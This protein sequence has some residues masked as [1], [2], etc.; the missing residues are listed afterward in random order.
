MKIAKYLRADLTRVIKRIQF[1]D[2]FSR[3]KTTLTKSKNIID[4]IW[5]SEL[6]CASA[7]QINVAI[8]VSDND[9]N[10]DGR[11]QFYFY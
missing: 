9:H 7:V 4:P 10:S 6:P 1:N 3:S 5:I 2:F 8:L 11:C